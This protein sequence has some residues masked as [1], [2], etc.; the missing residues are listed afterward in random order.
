MRQLVASGAC[1][2]SSAPIRVLLGERD[3]QS[4]ES[5]R[6]SI[7]GDPCFVVVAQTSSATATVNEALRWRPDVCVVSIDLPGGALAATWEITSRLRRTQV[8]VVTD[9]LDD[10]QFLKAVRAGARGYVQGAARHGLPRA[11]HAVAGGEP[12]I[13]RQLHSRV[14]ELLCDSGA[15]RR[16]VTDHLPGQRLTSREWQVA[17]LLARGLSTAEIAARL[18]V[19][20]E[21]IRTHIA[22]IRRKLRA[23]DRAAAVRALTG[24]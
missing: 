3:C 12:A 22:A 20:P 14:L 24:P 17:D 16:M 1:E 7:L 13:P 19:S 11:L 21:T 18:F 4:R 2:A 9:R 23:P 6:T 8:V 10:R 15:R 5:S